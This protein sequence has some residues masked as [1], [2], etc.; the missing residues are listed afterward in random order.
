M[1]VK[2]GE[3]GGPVSHRVTY[4]IRQLFKQY[5]I[6]YIVVVVKVKSGESPSQVGR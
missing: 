2:S 4:H 6:Y 5:I 3:S 1:K